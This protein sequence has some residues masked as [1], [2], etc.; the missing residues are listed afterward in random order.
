MQPKNLLKSEIL[1]RAKRT[2][3]LLK[4]M[5]K[6]LMKQTVKR[7]RNYIQKRQDFLQNQNNYQLMPGLPVKYLMH[8][9]L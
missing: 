4:Y 5:T 2:K 7:S 9:T 3:K 1:K 8:L 6:H